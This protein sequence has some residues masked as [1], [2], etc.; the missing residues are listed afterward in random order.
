M[1]TTV[2]RMA[3]A[4]MAAV[5]G[6]Q[7]LAQVPTIDCQPNSLAQLNTGQAS[8]D[9]PSVDR[10]WRYQA[11]SAYAGSDPANWG[12]FGNAYIV[13]PIVGGWTS[14]PGGSG[15]AKWIGA[16]T[17]G[18]QPVVA[19][20]T[21]AWGNVDVLFQV[22]FNL[23]STVSLPSFQPIMAF[24]ADNSVVDIFVN[25][26]SQLA[27]GA[28]TWGLPQAGGAN[29]FNYVGFGFNQWMTINPMTSPDWVHGLN[30]L[31][32]YIKSSVTAMGF[33]A[34]MSGSSVCGANAAPTVV[35]S[36]AGQVQV[37]QQLQGTYVYA[38]AESDPEDTSASGTSYQWVS[39]ASTVLTQSSQGTVRATGATM[40]AS[41]QVSYALQGG[42]IGQYLYYCVTPRA[43]SGTLVGQEACSAAAGPV[44]AP[45][46]ATP[47]PTL[48][49]WM[50]ALLGG[51]M[52]AAAV[53]GMRRRPMH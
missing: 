31:T 34:S 26:H 2:I 52:A 11:L 33:G 3:L 4:A 46:A 12:A 19:G 24:S 18:G 21:N 20:N 16:S 49:Q 7:A 44:R 32:I 22:Q 9:S 10:L 36:V 41:G 47:V 13:N 1:K 42:D 43:I 29:Q 15:A 17:G 6:G 28:G 50:V 37:G 30:T 35:P 25:G 40:G 5:A 27:R 45:I 23:A 8:S 51:L 39:S 14:T 38:D 48:G 53:L